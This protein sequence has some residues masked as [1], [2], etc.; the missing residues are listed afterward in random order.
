MPIIE[1]IRYFDVDSSKRFRPP[2]VLIHGSGSDHSI[3]PHQLRR[4]PGWHVITIDL[5]GHGGSPGAALAS[6]EEYA[7]KIW[8]FLN[9]LKIFHVILL[10]HSMGGMI[11]LEMALLEPERVS[12]LI[13]L[14]VSRHPPRQPEL[15]ASLERPADRERMLKILEKNLF[16]PGCDPALKKQIMLSLAPA[17]LSV[18]CADWKLALGYHVPENLQVTECPVLIISGEDDRM[19]PPASGRALAAII[20][21]ARFEIIPKAGHS[22]FLEQT[23]LVAQRLQVFLQ[24]TQFK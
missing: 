18:L 5:P 24:E 23:E 21:H 3:W 6:I 12:S 16:S 2:L 10:G 17:R 20:P 15:C 13:M 7:L 9:Q 22:L 8:A 4:L 19:T 1:D 11:A 14:G